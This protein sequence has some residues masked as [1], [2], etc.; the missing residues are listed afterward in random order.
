MT[1][2]LRL[3]LDFFVCFDKPGISLWTRSLRD[4]CVFF[5]FFINSTL[6]SLAGL[7][8]GALQF[9]VSA[10]KPFRLYRMYPDKKNVIHPAA[11]TANNTVSRLF[12]ILTTVF[13]GALLCLMLKLLQVD[14]FRVQQCC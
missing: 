5:Y 12:L 3:K 14:G 8:S 13:K 9:M 11:E 4:V 1:G 2:F 10:L 7:E 6:T